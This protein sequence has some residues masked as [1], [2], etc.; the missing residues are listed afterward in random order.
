[1]GIPKVSSDEIRHGIFEI[2]SRRSQK[3]R[4][5]DN[6]DTAR[7]TTNPSRWLDNPNRF[8]FAGIDT[9][10]RVKPKGFTKTKG[11]RA[12]KKLKEVFK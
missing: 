5:V 9:V 3:A 2:N 11:K 1:M 7:L 10:V 6:A 12:A 4:D 8:D